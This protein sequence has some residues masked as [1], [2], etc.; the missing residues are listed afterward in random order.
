MP[1]H[2]EL[3]A[4]GRIIKAKGL[5][6]ELKVESLSD[7]EHRFEFLESVFI[8]QKNG[9]I[10]TKTV[11]T[12]KSNGNN[13]I[14]KLKDI[15]DRTAAEA[16]HGAYIYVDRRNIAPLTQDSYYIFE[17]EGMD[18]IDTAGNKIG[19]VLRVDK[20]PANDVIIIGMEKEDIMIPA[21]K[22]CILSVDNQKNQMTVDIPDGLPVY[23]KGIL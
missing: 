8:E 9:L 2:D 5:R 18:V 21:V 13:V 17:L 4:I 11:E 16:Y 19:K 7:T 1:R 12:T 14:V 3:I 23:P 6:G 15:D 22:H 20:Y 10:V